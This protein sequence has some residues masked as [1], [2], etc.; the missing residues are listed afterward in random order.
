MEKKIFQIHSKILN[1][2]FPQVIK[3]F[4]QKS[5][6]KKGSKN[7]QFNYFIRNP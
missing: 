1:F 2:K 7:L 5:M 4:K 3:Q 6:R